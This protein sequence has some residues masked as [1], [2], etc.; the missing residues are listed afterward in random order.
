MLPQQ[1]M[2]V[3]AQNHKGPTLYVKT[4]GIQS[5]LWNFAELYNFL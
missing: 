2:N 1:L 5:L 4:G 3:M